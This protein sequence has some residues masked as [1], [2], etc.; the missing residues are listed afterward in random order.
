MRWR[1]P[2]ILRV[3]KLNLGMRV[4]NMPRAKRIRVLLNNLEYKPGF[5]ILCSSLREKENE[6]ETPTINR[7][8][9]K[10][11]SVGV[12]PCHSACL[13]G[14][15]TCVQLPGLLTNIIPA[16]VSPRKASKDERRSLFK[17]SF[18][19]VA[20]KIKKGGCSATSSLRNV[21]SFSL[22]I[23]IGDFLRCSCFLSRTKEQGNFSSSQRNILYNSQSA[24]PKTEV[25]YFYHTK[26]E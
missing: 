21:Y 7:K 10:T 9:G 1:T 20:L 8:K 14:A 22:N 6:M 17:I 25:K 4:R 24:L 2:G 15:Y 13:R 19:W 18:S 23:A 3:A 5:S 11:R 12:Q 26:A 16:M